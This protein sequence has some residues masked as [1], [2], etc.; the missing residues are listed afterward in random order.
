[1]SELTSVFN[2]T[3]DTASTIMAVNLV[4]VPSSKDTVVVFSPSPFP[5]PSPSPPPP[6][7]DSKTGP[8]RPNALNAA[9]VG[10]NGVNS[11]KERVMWFIPLAISL[12]PSPI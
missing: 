11:A 7:T 9:S 10:K 4:I 5:S 12:K 6:I 3:L 1:M 8:I 2:V